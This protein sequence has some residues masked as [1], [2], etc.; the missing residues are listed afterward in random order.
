MDPSGGLGQNVGPGRA[1]SG[2]LAKIR[3]PVRTKK[4]GPRQISNICPSKNGPCPDLNLQN[5]AGR[6]AQLFFGGQQKKVGIGSAQVGGSPGGRDLTKAGWSCLGWL[7]R[8]GCW[9]VLGP[10]LGWLAW[11]GWPGLAG[12]LGLKQKWRASS[13]PE[14]SLWGNA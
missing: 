4:N 14:V 10:G 7:V 3:G 6:G 1:P 11:A 2:G 5:V 13:G 8:E 12:P 9:L